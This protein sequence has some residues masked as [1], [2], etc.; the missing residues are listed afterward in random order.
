MDTNWL[1]VG[2]VDEIMTCVPAPGGKGF[3]LLLAS[4]RLAYRI[5]RR[6][7]SKGNGS[8][9][10]LKGRDFHGRPAEVTISGFLTAGI[11]GLSLTALEFRSFNG[12][13][14]TRLAAIQKKLEKD[15]SLKASDI[16][17]VPILF[18][19][20]D[21]SPAFADALTTGMVNMLVLNKHC[22]VPK[23]FGPV[24]GGTDL[25]EEN[26]R[27]K[28]GRLG[29]TVKFI[30]DWHEYHVNLGEVHCGTNTLRKPVPAK[31]KWWEFTP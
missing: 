18:M 21:S 16:L 4:P 15:L 20:N 2:H 28:L 10:M 12:M 19:P 26:L 17:E 9:K 7:V 8:E 13:A 5:L 22:I 3:K 11:P 27:S 30:D 14:G 29:L 1:L 6:A 31:W 25:F 24:V 23:P